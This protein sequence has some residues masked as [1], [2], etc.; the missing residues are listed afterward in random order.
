MSTVYELPDAQDQWWDLVWYLPSED[1]RSTGIGWLS[2]DHVCGGMSVERFCGSVQSVGEAARNKLIS[3][4]ADEV[5]S[6]DRLGLDY[7]VTEKSRA[8]FV[9][10]LEN[11]GLEPGALA[12][13][14]QGVY[15][16][17]NTVDVRRMLGLGTPPCEGVALL[18]LGQNCD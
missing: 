18:V 12:Q 14:T 4:I 6:S 3:D 11:K 7:A 8:E 9:A 17:A 15:P 13:L 5:W 16:I 1:P 10:F 2:L